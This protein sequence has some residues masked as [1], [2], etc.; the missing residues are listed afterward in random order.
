MKISQAIK[1]GHRSLVSHKRRNL[2]TIIIVGVMFGFMMGVIFLTQGVQNVVRQ[3]ADAA[4]GDN[5]YVGIQTDFYN[6]K[7]CRQEPILGQEG[8]YNI[9]CEPHDLEQL[10]QKVA[11]LGGEVLAVSNTRLMSLSPEAAR[12]FIQVNLESVPDTVVPV[13]ESTTMALFQLYGDKAYNMNYVELA[14]LIRDGK[15]ASVLGQ[16]QEITYN[17]GATLM[18]VGILASGRITQ[19]K[20]DAGASFNPLD[21]ILEFVGMNSNMLGREIVIDNRSPATLDYLDYFEN[22]ENIAENAISAV[23]RFDNFAAAEQFASQNT[24]QIYEDSIGCKKEFFL[25]SMFDNRVALART[26]E[27]IWWG[28]GIAEMVLLTLAVVITLFTLLKVLHGE[29][30]SIT[31]YRSLGASTS[32]IVMIYLA[33]TAEVCLLAIGFAILMGLGIA[34]IASLTNTSAMAD[35]L[36]AAY[37]K[38]INGP[39]ILVGWNWDILKI[40]FVMLLVA[41]LSLLCSANTLRKN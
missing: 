37:G 34:L 2:T 28:L 4:L 7:R 3:A 26:G 12:P 27:M 29:T 31:L 1:L 38:V 22:M 35:M 24:C 13:L 40:I 16:P 19:L 14:N 36:T 10:R 5:Y 15:L 32:D 18:P 25:E 21:Y 9:I 8:H 11:A 30:K 17:G 41:L 39:F 20:T 23:L 33:Y 6:E